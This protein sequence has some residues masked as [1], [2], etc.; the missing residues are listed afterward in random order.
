M[1]R[2]AIEKYER[3]G[4]VFPECPES[5]VAAERIEAL[6]RKREAEDERICP[7]WIFMKFLRRPVSCGDTFRPDRRARIRLFLPFPN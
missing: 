7:V 1:Y 5:K 6:S 4:Q 2:G 3:I